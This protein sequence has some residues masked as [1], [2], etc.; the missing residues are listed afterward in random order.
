MHTVVAQVKEQTKNKKNWLCLT[1]FLEL[2][3]FLL[4][5]LNVHDKK[6]RLKYNNAAFNA[7]ASLSE[8]NL[9]KDY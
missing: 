3:L 9:T 6:A 8:E 1:S 7:V 4:Q 2:Y 5:S